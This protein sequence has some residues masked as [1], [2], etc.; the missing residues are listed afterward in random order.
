MNGRPK[1]RLLMQ[2]KKSG[3]P[4]KRRRRLAQVAVALGSVA[5][6]VGSLVKIAEALRAIW[7]MAFP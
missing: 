2:K 1:N 3:R 5:A 6:I 7:R 4:T